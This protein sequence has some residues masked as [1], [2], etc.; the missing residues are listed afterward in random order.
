MTGIIGF[1]FFYSFSVGPFVWVFVAEVMPAAGISMAIT[2]DWIMLAA[3][4][5]MFKPLA[6]IL[7]APGMFWIFA[8][9]D[10]FVL[11]FVLKV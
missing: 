1:V 11:C 10:F 2:V 6:N 7:T 5:Y 8:G 4:S 9:F 3:N